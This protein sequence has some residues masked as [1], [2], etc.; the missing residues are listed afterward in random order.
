MTSSPHILRYFSLLCIVSASHAIYYKFYD[1]AALLLLECI[2]S[3]KYWSDPENNLLRNIDRATT[4]INF[5]Y[6]SYFHHPLI[7]CA[8]PIT[9]FSYYERYINHNTKKADN[10]WMILH[11]VVFLNVNFIIWKR[12]YHS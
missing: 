3:H 6:F 8:I 10:I 11:I 5:A 1:F 2:V 4:L 7:Y 9:L 12:K